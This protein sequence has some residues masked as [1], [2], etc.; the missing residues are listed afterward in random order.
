MMDSH[1]IDTPPIDGMVR[2]LGHPKDGMVQPESLLTDMRGTAWR[3]FYTDSTGLLTEL[4]LGAAY[5]WLQSS[6]ASAAP[7]FAAL[8]TGGPATLSSDVALTNSATWYDGPSFSLAAGTWLIIGQGAMTTLTDQDLV[9][10][11]I[12]SAFGTH[13]EIQTRCSSDAFN[14]N[15]STIVTLA[16]ST[17]VVLSA[18]N[19]THGGGTLAKNADSILTTSLVAVR[20]A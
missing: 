16:G 19:E 18:R 6:G 15:I 9:K 8:T 3:L 7:A 17:T 12:Y 10:L 20:V 13:A 11:R 1:A 5:T 14:G 4:A 2:A